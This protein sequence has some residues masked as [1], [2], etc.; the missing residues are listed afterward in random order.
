[1]LIGTAAAR[2]LEI[3]DAEHNPIADNCCSCACSSRGGAQP[4]V[5]VA[6]FIDAY[7]NAR[8]QNHDGSSQ[9][10]VAATRPVRK[11]SQE[12][13]SQVYPSNDLKRA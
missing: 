7:P 5:A 2:Y 4:T 3:I 13:A 12:Y 8:N 6:D 10:Q 1:L 9:W 11:R